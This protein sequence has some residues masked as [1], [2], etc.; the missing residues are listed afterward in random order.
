[1]SVGSSKP[2]GPIQFKS[3][4]RTGEPPEHKAACQVIIDHFK[5]KNYNVFANLKVWKSQGFITEDGD[6]GDFGQRYFYFLDILAQ[7]PI[8]DNISSTYW[9]E[10]DGD[11][12]TNPWY[13]SKDR[14]KEEIVYMIIH[15]LDPYLVR[16]KVDELVKTRIK[17]KWVEPV[18]TRF[19]EIEQQL[20]IRRHGFYVGLT[21]F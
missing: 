11:I 14:K 18:F 21:G 15:K 20:R 9:V 3:E 5:T 6:R 19:D 2:L 17:G 1:M 13:A 7:R 4:W 12:H 16:F 10:V 8:D